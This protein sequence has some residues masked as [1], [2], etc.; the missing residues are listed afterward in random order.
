MRGTARVIR[1]SLGA[2]PFPSAAVEIAVTD[3]RDHSHDGVM[4]SAPTVLYAHHKTHR[5]V[6]ED[7]IFAELREA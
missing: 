4:T 6:V 1:E 3:V 5:Y 2:V 7:A